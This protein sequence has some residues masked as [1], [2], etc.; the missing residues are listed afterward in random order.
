MCPN[1]PAF[2]GKLCLLIVVKSVSHEEQADESNKG[3]DKIVLAPRKYLTTQLIPTE[4]N[5]TKFIVSLMSNICLFHAAFSA[6][7]RT[8]WVMR[9]SQ[10]WLRT[11]G[12][13]GR[14]VLLVRL[15]DVSPRDHFLVVH[16]TE[17]RKQVVESQSRS[18]DR[19]IGKIH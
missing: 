16:N 2:R 19:Q 13:K 12:R 14:I 15:L 4:R 6:R 17:L 9:F 5:G 10:F 3:S 8:T 1:C 11:I 7:P 18:I